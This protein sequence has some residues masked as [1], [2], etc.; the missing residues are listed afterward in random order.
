MADVSIDMSEVRALEHDMR[1]VD[2]RLTRHVIP[3]VD[4]AAVNIKADMRAAAAKSRHFRMASSITYDKPN[5]YEAEIG[6]TKGGAGS[7]A[8]IAYFGGSNGGGGTIED[9]RGAM[10]REAPK[11]ERALAD[12]A[13]ELV[14]GR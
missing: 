2:S 7:L 9:P 13:A 14:L 5:P 11:F 1:A 3:V 4:K 8:N 6:P 12:L 10:D